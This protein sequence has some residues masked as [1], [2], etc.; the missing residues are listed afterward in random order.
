M[1]RVAS[2]HTADTYESPFALRIVMMCS[3]AGTLMQ[4]LD[5]TIANVALPH[6][7]GS[8][9]ASRDQI[10]WVLT[11]YIVASAIMTAPVGWMASR[12]G[13][14][15]L[16]L[17]SM[18]GFTVTSMM[19]GLAQSLE[20]M[21]LFRLLQ[22]AFGAALS[23]L[24]QSIMLDLYPPQ[25]RGNI[26]AIWGMG[27]ML[28]PI[29]GPTLGG[30]LTD[31]YNWRWVF[32][33]NV[34]F[35]IAAVSGIWLY[36]QDT[37]SDR[38]MRFDWFG[39][40]ALGIGLGALQLMLDR[41]TSQNWF[42]SMEIVVEALI[43]GI[44]LYLFIVH[45]MTAK[46]PFIP[47]QIFRDRN[48][49]AALFLMFVVG[50]ILL[51][52]SALLPPYLQNLAGYSV[53]DTG[54]LMAPRGFG[55]MFAMMFAG[56][57]ALRVDPRVLMTMGTAFMLWSMW[58]MSSWTPQIGPMELMTTTF[59]QGFGMGF[60]FV[61]MNLMAFATL[62]GHLRTDGSALSNLTRNFGSAIGV[63]LTTS[64]L[65][66]SVQIMHSMLSGYA[67]PFNRA[68]GVNAPAMM[69]NPQ[70][71]FGLQTLNG[72]IELR[73]EVAAYAN[74]YLMMVYISLPAFL[75]IWMMRRPDFSAA[76]P[77]TSVEVTE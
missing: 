63:S 56:R 65:G 4:A 69:M 2:T 27:V 18:I 8:M 72:L 67:S 7:Q 1:P 12:F 33:V 62:P 10:T 47:P 19:C 9:S 35:G 58:E 5:T 54:L 3:M 42:G 75:I 23:P 48:F 29:L 41:G 25:K 76:P 14:K 37:H 36:F 34:P 13:K 6:M 64:V 52:S 17:V 49:L 68:L 21:I 45:M 61:P 24:S 39:F 46:T 59:V 60:V 32:Y 15:N 74:V 73:S 43:A 11:S 66:G 53:T 51:A 31:A 20:Q 38:A 30:W 50:A 44:G 16:M 28:G 71:P 55:T 22:G 57:L 26:M 40:A 70:L 77:M